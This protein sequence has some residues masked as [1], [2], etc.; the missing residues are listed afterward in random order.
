[1]KKSFLFISLLMMLIACG[2]K[3]TESADNATVETTVTADSRDATYVKA[4]EDIVGCI[5]ALYAAA[6]KNEADIDGRF[7]CDAWRSMVAAVEEKDA[8]VGEIGFFN[9]DYWTEM[10]DSNPDD[11]KVSDIKFEQLDVEKGTAL[12][13]F[14][15]YSSIQ[16][17]HRQF[18]F[19]HEDGDWR[20]H[21]I[22]R[23]Y[24][25]SDGVETFSS[26]LNDMQN[27][28]NEPIDE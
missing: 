1:M 9:E 20:V 24:N 3:K 15:L 8:Q 12:V 26:L 25:V 16:T 22:I 21:D 19:C 11:L 28:V 6:A 5:N 17:I 10:Q 27:Y 14:M 13:D 4:K 18:A 2:G 23:F 7:A